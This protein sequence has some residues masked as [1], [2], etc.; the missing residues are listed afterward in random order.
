MLKAFK[1]YK[2]DINFMS[3][4]AC[5]FRKPMILYSKAKD[6]HHTIVALTPITDFQ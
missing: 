2:N 5:Y 3:G 4:A 6:Y 1:K